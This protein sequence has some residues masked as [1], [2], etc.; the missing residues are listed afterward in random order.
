MRPSARAR[1][2][3][4]SSLFGRARRTV[5]HSL[6]D[7]QDKVAMADRRG[8]S[9]LAF[10][11]LAWVPGPQHQELG[12]DMVQRIRELPVAVQTLVLQVGAELRPAR[13]GSAQVAP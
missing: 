10:W 13:A 1:V 4:G 8:R 12:H 2:V 7:V 6:G 3:F 9:H 5:V 11:P